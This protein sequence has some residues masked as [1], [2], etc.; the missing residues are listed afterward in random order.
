VALG[1]VLRELSE[2]GERLALK[3]P[4]DVLFDGA[5]LSGMLLESCYLP[6]GKFACVIGLGVNLTSHPEGLAYPAT[7]L[8]AIGCK[9]DTPEALLTL[10]SRRL[11]HWLGVWKEPDGFLAIRREWLKLAAGLG[12]EVKIMTATGPLEGCM[13]TIDNAGRLILASG[14]K[15]IAISAGDVFFTSDQISA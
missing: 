7:D 4:N 3:W 13:K 6:N 14:D 10:I 12:A 8:A 11:A 9:I 2:A 15:E 1:S 5:K